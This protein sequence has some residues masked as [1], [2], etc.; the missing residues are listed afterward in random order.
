MYN[1][2]P[3]QDVG[4]KCRGGGGH[5]VGV[6]SELYGTDS[7]AETNGLCQ[8]CTLPSLCRSYD[9]ALHDELWFFSIR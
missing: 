2:E 6:Y 9:G 7:Y 4:P 5:A 1:N 3:M 8:C